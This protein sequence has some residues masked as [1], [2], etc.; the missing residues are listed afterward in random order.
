MGLEGFSHLVGP[1]WLFSSKA[2]LW[3]Q[4]SSIPASYSLKH[5]F[6]V[7]L[8]LLFF[9]FLSGEVEFPFTELQ[10]GVK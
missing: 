5:V 2:R 1:W 10:T 6:V 4:G 7:V 8:L 9:V 3:R